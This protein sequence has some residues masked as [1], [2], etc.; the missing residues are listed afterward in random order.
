MPTPAE[1]HAYQHGCERASF[2]HTSVISDVIKYALERTSEGI[3]V[4]RGCGY[5]FGCDLE[6]ADPY[7]AVSNASIVLFASIDN[8]RERLFSSWSKDDRLQRL[9]HCVYE[10]GRTAYS[11][12][13]S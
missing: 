10:F 11:P 13:V 4:H 7:E 3:V 2:C 12:N 6:V 8:V 1:K 5:C 9:T